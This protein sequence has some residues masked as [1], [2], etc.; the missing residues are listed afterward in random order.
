MKKR[1]DIIAAIHAGIR[2]AAN[3][4][5]EWSGGRRLH[6]DGI[7]NLVSVSVAGAL[8]AA[9][10]IEKNT[11]RLQLETRFTSI[12]EESGRKQPKGRPQTAWSKIKAKVKGRVDISI[13]NRANQPVGL[14]ELKRGPNAR[15]ARADVERLAAFCEHCGNQYSGSVQYGLFG[16]YLVEET[17][18]R[19]DP[20]ERKIAKIRDEVDD[21]K[22]DRVAIRFHQSEEYT[23]LTAQNGSK[24]R[25][26]SLV[27]EVAA[28]YP[29][30]EPTGR[31]DV[32]VE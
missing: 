14:I 5:A 25:A 31:S 23:I 6:D 20:I 22:S 17:D 9:R 11:Y 2:T 4:Y 13:W 32:A 27:V 7:E 26:M 29:K 21:L 19:T 24:T 12:E 1:A 16:V 18:K 3:N 15:S 30:K 28:R 8:W 10:D